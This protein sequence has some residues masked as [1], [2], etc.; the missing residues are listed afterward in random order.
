[1]IIGVTGH[2]DAQQE[3]GE[4]EQF[5]RLSVARMIGQGVTEIITGMALGWDIAIAEAADEAGVPFCAT[6]PF[7]AQSSRWSEEDQVRYYRACDRASRVIFVGRLE[8]TVS[9]IK[10]DRWIVDHCEELWALDSGCPSGTH[11][12]VLYAEEVGRKVVSLWDDW[13]RHQARR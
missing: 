5:A 6:I 10:R 4:L 3:P 13:I 7:P 2:R 1:M 12:T 9:Y 11:T 8:L